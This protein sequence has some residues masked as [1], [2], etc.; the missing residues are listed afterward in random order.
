MRVNKIQ[1]QEI[2]TRISIKVK[3]MHGQ[4]VTH[5][6]QV[7]VLDKVEKLTELL[8]LKEPDEIE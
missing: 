7:S 6:L 4:R 3:T 2:K 1:R 5:T 8:I